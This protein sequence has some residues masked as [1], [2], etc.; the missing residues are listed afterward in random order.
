MSKQIE[1]QILSDGKKVYILKHQFSAYTVML[2]YAEPMRAPT[3]FQGLT[4]T[5][6]YEKMADIMQVDMFDGLD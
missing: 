4:K 5:Q 2:T 3:L 6:A 1:C